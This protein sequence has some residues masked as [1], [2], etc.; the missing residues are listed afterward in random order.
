ML[1]SWAPHSLLFPCK[2]G[3]GRSTYLCPCPLIPMS[4]QQLFI[5]VPNN[6]RHKFG[7]NH[8]LLNLYL[9][10]MCNKKLLILFPIV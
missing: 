2:K 8:S 6:I 4:V 5:T 3:A 1:T 10:N 7:M 9:E